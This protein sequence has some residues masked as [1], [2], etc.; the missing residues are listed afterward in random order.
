MDQLNTIIEKTVTK[1]ETPKVKIPPSKTQNI[2]TR[3]KRP[4]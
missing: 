4:H 1:I 2:R 3:I